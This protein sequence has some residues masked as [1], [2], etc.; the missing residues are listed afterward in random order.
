MQTNFYCTYLEIIEFSYKCLKTSRWIEI[1]NSKF[2]TLIRGASH[3]Y[4]KRKIL[5]WLCP[6]NKVCPTDELLSRSIARFI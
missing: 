1:K 5:I 6:A 2:R 4:V 3:S